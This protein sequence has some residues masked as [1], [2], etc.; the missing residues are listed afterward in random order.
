M[1]FSL[2]CVCFSMPQIFSPY[3]E[4]SQWIGAHPNQVL[5]HPNFITSAKTYFPNKVTYI[6]P[7]VR[8][9]TCLFGGHNSTH[10]I[11]EWESL[12]EDTK[13]ILSLASF[14]TLWSLSTPPFLL[15]SLLSCRSCF[16]ILGILWDICFAD[17]FSRPC[18]ENI[19]FLNFWEIKLIFN[20]D[21]M[22]FMMFSFNDYWFLWSF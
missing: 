4:T 12:A 17:I 13:N 21:E 15:F 3:K 2:V 20:F 22:E 18:L 8:T 6:G 10:N 11:R 14:L 19:C 7:G 9:W 5:P 1:T 16:C